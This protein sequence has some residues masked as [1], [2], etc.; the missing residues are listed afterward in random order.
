MASQRMSYREIWPHAALSA[1][2][3]RFWVRSREEGNGGALEVLPPRYV[4]PDGC[5]DILI[6]L[7][8][9]SVHVVGAMTSALA[10]RGPGQALAAV[11]FRPG[12]AA[13]LLGV[14]AQEL[15]DRRVPLAEVSGGWLS[16]RVL[17]AQSPHAALRLLEASLLR[18]A[19]VVRSRSAVAQKVEQAVRACFGPTPP[20][21][22]ALAREVGC[23]RQRLTQ[24]LL[25]QVGLG[26]KD[27]LRVGRLQR[28]VA[29]LQGGPATLAETA[30]GLGYFDQ[31]H[32]CR[33]FRELV[34]VSPGV[35][36]A[37]PLTIFP[38]HSL[39]SGA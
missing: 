23:S 27:L 24:V 6:G 7:D 32:M 1:V 39:L 21:V 33:D 10:V 26:A 4:L 20:A 30:L 18:R 11:R 22:S 3:D 9:R 16:P 2:V 29:E 19:S 28:A 8:A 12:A 37:S 38:I 13:A 25:D 14:S 5:I 17:D 31:A 15:T 35:V 34:G 36:R